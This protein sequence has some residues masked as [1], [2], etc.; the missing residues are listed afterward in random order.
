MR[1]GILGGTG[2]RSII[3]DAETVRVET[4]WGAVPVE[5][6]RVGDLL[7]FFVSR[8]GADHGRSAHRVAHK[9][10]L[11]ALAAC[12]TDAV[13]AINNVGGLREPFTT[14]DLVVPHDLVALWGPHVTIHEAEAVH[15]D[16]TAPYC[17]HLR[18]ALVTAASET[19]NGTVHA[20]GVYVQ[21]PG[22]RLET[23]AEVRHLATMGD[24]VG[25]TGGPEAVLARE[26]G[27]CFAS[28]AFVANPAA[29]REAGPV[30]ADALRK[31]LADV[32]VALRDTVVAAA[33]AVPRDRDCGCREAPA[34]GRMAPVPMRQAHKA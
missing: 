28:L 29:G 4:A 2:S 33:R 16:M 6:G 21:V 22:P 14:G 12:R 20:E 15:V 11:A 7:V 13:F 31:A 8:H 24:V 30:V 18:S 19:W 1:I 3:D 34:K 23:A 17:P 27:L 5:T 9:A 32:S 25:M 26:L 10:N